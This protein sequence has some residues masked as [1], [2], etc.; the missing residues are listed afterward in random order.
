MELTREEPDRSE[1]GKW[2]AG[3]GFDVREVHPLAGDVSPRR[4]ERMTAADGTTTILA[5]YQIGR[6]SCRERV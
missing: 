3:A 1:L 5:L 2:L 6:A 4:Y